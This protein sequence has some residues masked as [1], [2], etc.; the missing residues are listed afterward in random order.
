MRPI[1]EFTSYRSYLDEWIRSQGPAGHGLKGQVAKAL[2][3]SSSLVSQVLKGD[4]TLTPDQTSSLCDFL[5]LA[6]VEA[7]YLHLLVELDRAATP[8]FKEKLSKKIQ[9]LR[10]NSK[11]LGL[12]IPKQKE[13]ADEQKAIFYSSWLYSGIRNLSALPEMESASRIAEH[14]HLDASVANRIVRFLI[15]NGLCKEENGKLTYGPA[16]TQVYRD[17]PFV[18]KHHQNWRFQAIQQMELRRDD[19]LFFTSPMSMSREAAGEIRKLLTE[20]IQSAIKTAGPSD[21]EIVAC[22]NLDW[23][24]Y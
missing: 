24:R 1:Y 5:G 22:L 7:D 4:K 8:R 13:L 10:D 11:K 17:S 14:L 12:R 6:E 18:N 20:F 2:G 23:F 16:S 21:S 9:A 19:D 15:E 3:V